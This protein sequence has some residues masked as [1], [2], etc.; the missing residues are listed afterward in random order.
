MS[1]LLCV[2]SFSASTR[3]A[4]CQT[5]S[6]RVQRKGDYCLTEK[7]DYGTLSWP[8]ILT[9]STYVTHATVRYYSH[10]LRLQPERQAMNFSPFSFLLRGQDTLS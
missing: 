8:S 10:C 9:R 4:F 2:A 7:A 5:E 6:R 1:A 3:T